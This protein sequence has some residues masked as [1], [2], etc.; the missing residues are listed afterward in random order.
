MSLT[1][2]SILIGIAN[3]LSALLTGPALARLIGA[4]RARVTQGA[5]WAVLALG[6]TVFLLFGVL[7]GFPGFRWF[8]PLMIP[9]AAVNFVVWWRSGWTSA[10]ALRRTP[11]QGA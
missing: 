11:A 4:R 8:Q 2:L 6:Q 5:G 1:L 3:P 9:V 7:S 10:S